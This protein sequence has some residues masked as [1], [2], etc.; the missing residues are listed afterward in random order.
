MQVGT[1]DH[2]REFIYAKEQFEEG[3]RSLDEEDKRFFK[4]FQD[5]TFE[6]SQAAA[7]KM[8]KIAKRRTKHHQ[9]WLLF[10]SLYLL[11]RSDL[12]MLSWPN[13]PLVVLLR[14]VN[15]NALSRH[16]NAPLQEGETRITPLLMLADLAAP[17]D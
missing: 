11:I 14:F 16:E 13:N 6:G 1:D 5:S 3:E 8:K 7:R 12:K 17:S 9:K 2:E 4:L 15:P 10:H